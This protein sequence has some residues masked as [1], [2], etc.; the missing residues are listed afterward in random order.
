MFDIDSTFNIIKIIVYFGQHSNQVLYYT[1][2]RLLLFYFDNEYY[3]LYGQRFFD[4][5]FLYEGYIPI[6]EGLEKLLEYLDLKKIIE[7]ND[8]DYG[9]YILPLIFL[10]E[11]EYTE[12]ELIVLNRILKKI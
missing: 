8:S 7:F 11:S 9:R 2:L 3:H 10:K 6:L 4:R 12:E 5:D 1:K